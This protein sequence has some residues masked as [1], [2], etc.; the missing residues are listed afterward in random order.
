MPRIEGKLRLGGKS[1]ETS[2]KPAKPR[3]PT[4]QEVHARRRA[5][6]D[7]VLAELI[8]QFPTLFDPEHP[9]PLALRLSGE[10]VRATSGSWSATGLALHHWTRRRRYLE[11]LA[12][13]D[14]QRYNLDGTISEP[15]SEEHRQHARDQLAAYAARPQHKR[16]TRSPRSSPSHRKGDGAQP[17]LPAEAVPDPKVTTD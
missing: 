8:A 1:G 16:K 7:A 12:A 3:Q 15:V 9:R 2:P 17:G 4:S 11:A 14:A 5:A 13:P 6:A 10:L